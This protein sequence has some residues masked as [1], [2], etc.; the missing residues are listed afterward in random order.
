MIDVD[1]LLNNYFQNTDEN[2]EKP[3]LKTAASVLK[4]LVHQEEI[5][6]F[7]ETHRH[8]VGLEFNDAVL[9]HFNFTFQVSGKDRSRIPDQGR[10]LIVA[11]HPLGS[12]DGLALLK[13]VS[14][15]SA[16]RIMISTSDSRNTSV[17]DSEK[18]R[19]MLSKAMMEPTVRPIAP[20]VRKVRLERCQRLWMAIPPTGSL[21]AL[22][23]LLPP[24]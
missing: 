1:A 19:T 10:V 7:I 23:P 5:N 14:E 9:E 18:P 20:R 2:P 15:M 13:L 3:L 8:L 21:R 12:L 17:K 11:N 24:S 6:Q 16:C 22:I 4:K